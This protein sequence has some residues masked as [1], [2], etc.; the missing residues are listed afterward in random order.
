MH[1]D[2][3]ISSDGDIFCAADCTH[4]ADEAAAAKD[5]RIEELLVEQIIIYT[6]L[7]VMRRCAKHRE[8]CLSRPNRGESTCVCSY[9]D[10]CDLMLAYTEGKPLP[11]NIIVNGRPYLVCHARL[12]YVAIVLLAGG[13]PDVVHSVTYVHSGGAKGILSPGGRVDIKDHMRLSA[14]VT[15][16]A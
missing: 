11:M 15:G 6:A 10:A 14:F 5:R 12:S 16:S 8:E 1:S 3:C 7:H 2:K 4:D 13:N 9:A